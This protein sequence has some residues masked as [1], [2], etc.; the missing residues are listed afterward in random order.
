MKINILLLS[1]LL[2]FIVSKSNAGCDTDTGGLWL[3]ATTVP[4]VGTSITLVCIAGG[5]A[6]LDK[7]MVL[8][9]ATMLVEENKIFIPSFLGT[10]A[11]Q[12]KMDI[13][14]AAQDVLVNGVR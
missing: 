5:G 1:L 4:P 14:E 8:R 9:E 3:T 7:E 10:Y 6:E 2:T 12:H 11:E 13:R